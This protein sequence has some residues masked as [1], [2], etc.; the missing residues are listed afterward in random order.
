MKYKVLLWF[1]TNE[2]SFERVI[3]NVEYIRNN[4]SEYELADKNEN[5]LFIAPCDHVFYIERVDE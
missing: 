2:N 1:P 3:D 5:T 4:G